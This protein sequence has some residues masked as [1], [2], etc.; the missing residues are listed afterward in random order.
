MIFG[1][2]GNGESFE[3]YEIFRSGSLFYLVKKGNF[4][5]VNE[6]YYDNPNVAYVDSCKWLRAIGK[7][8]ILSIPNW[9]CY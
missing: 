7:K 9:K 5:S 4:K 8:F 2:I 6:K 1:E 3:E